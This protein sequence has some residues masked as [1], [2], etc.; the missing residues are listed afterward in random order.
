MLLLL[1][2]LLLQLGANS[3]CPPGEHKPT[4]HQRDVFVQISGRFR[5]DPAVSTLKRAL[6]TGRPPSLNLRQ[7]TNETVWS[8]SLNLPSKIGY[9]AF[10]IKSLK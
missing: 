2:L 1:L 8:R 3:S 6:R 9:Y 5:S 4:T 7:H 10:P